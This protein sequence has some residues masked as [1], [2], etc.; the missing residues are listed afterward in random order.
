MSAED[1]E[2][3]KATEEEAMERIKAAHRRAEDLKKKA[4]AESKKILEDAAKKASEEAERIKR[5][6]AAK[7]KKEAKEELKRAEKE[8]LGMEQ[9]GRGR[10]KKAIELVVRQVS[11]LG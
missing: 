10:G 4:E 8:M 3:I 6:A 7:A 9:T 5:T 11:G 2:L 1:I